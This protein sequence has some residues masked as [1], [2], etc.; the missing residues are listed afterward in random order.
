MNRCIGCGVVLQVL[1]KEKDGYTTNLDNKL[2]Y[3]CFN[4][5][6]YNKCYSTSLDNNDYIEIINSIGENDLVLYVTSFF[7][8]RLDLIDTFKNV[9]VVLTKRDIIPK[10]VVDDKISGYIKKRYR[11]LDC[12][13][14][15]SIKNYNIDYLFEVIKKY[16]TTNNV[17]MIGCTNSGKSTL[18]NSFIKSY[19]NGIDFITSS[20]YASTTL[21]K[22]RVSIDKINFIDTPG[23][24][25][26][27][28][29]FSFIDSKTLK[30][31]NCKKEI[32]PRTYQLSGKGSIL[33]DSFVR[34][35]YDSLSTSMTIYVSNDVKVRFLGKDNKV[36]HEC[37]NSSFD[38]ENK[39][40]VISDFCF[41]KFTKRVKVDVYCNSCICVYERDNL[42]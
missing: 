14:V 23:L 37:K 13:V 28:S 22:I 38:I 4:I 12:V 6:N 19:G 9:I 20:M 34:L 15:S 29:V 8:I 21:D 7:D 32:K 41:I 35:D 10:S 40:I 26:N 27:G 33:I 18:I 42:I 36:M 2:C 5:R 1:D 16:N 24:I 17:Y 30:R 11:C 39:D 3:R 25:N 31:I